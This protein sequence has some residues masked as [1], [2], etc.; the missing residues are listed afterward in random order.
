VSLLRL[1]TRTR[2]VGGTGQQRPDLGGVAGVVQHDQ[3][4]ASVGQRAEQRRPGLQTVRDVGRGCA[5]GREEAGQGVGRVGGVG[6]GSAQVRVELAAG[7]GVACRVGGMDREGGLADPAHTSHHDHGQGL[8]Q[9][10]GEGLV[11]LRDLGRPAG[12]VG[13]VVRELGRARGRRDGR[14]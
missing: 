6:V 14:R 10:R 5:E 7:E 13:R 9:G 11:D 12:E 3:Q 4:S 2:A 8:A 1:V